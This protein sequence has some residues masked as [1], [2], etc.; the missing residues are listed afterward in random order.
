MKTLKIN[1]SFTGYIETKFITCTEDDVV[2][3]DD[4]IAKK[5]VDLKYGELV[6]SATKLNIKRSVQT[7]IKVI[8]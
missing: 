4:S 5:I 6:E 3:V 1:K 2:S 7:A 8:K